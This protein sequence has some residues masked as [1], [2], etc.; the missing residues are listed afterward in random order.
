MGEIK[1][2]KK[3]KDW[4]MDT[5]NWKIFKFIWVIANVMEVHGS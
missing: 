3:E 1:K 5:L 2:E 4:K